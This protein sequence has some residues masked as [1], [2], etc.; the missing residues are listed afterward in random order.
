MVCVNQT[1]C[2]CPPAL[3]GSICKSFVRLGLFTNNSVIASLLFCFLILILIDHFILPGNERGADTTS[4]DRQTRVEGSEINKSL[5]ALKVGLR[6]QVKS[7]YTGC[8]TPK[9]VTSLQCPSPCHCARATRLFTKKCRSG[10]EL[11]A[12][13]CPI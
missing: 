12:L 10:G 1:I 3:L 5:L 8:I 9:R 4:A 6:C 2:T 7:Y 13:L 11:L